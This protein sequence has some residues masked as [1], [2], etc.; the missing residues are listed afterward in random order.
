M[1]YYVTI[2]VGY[3]ALILLSGNQ[4]SSFAQGMFNG[5]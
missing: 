5:M 3:C 2:L 1:N 4:P